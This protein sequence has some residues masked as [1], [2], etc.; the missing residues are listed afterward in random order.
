VF[1][2]IHKKQDLLIERLIFQ[3]RQ[4]AVAELKLSYGEEVLPFDVKW[5]K[6]VPYLND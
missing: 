1:E 3:M 5:Q 4:M 6:L 2:S